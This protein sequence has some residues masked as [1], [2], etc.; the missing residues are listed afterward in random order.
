MTSSRLKLIGGLLLGL[1][2][3][4]SGI[5]CG[6]LGDSLYVGAVQNQT[7]TGITASY[8]FFNGTET[9]NIA[10]TAGDVIDFSYKSTVAE[11]SLALKLNDA[12]KNTVIEFPADTS[13]VAS[14]TAQKAGNFTLVIHGED[15][16]G[17]YDISWE[18]NKK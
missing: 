16:K 17:S 8:Q 6:S 18:I 3:I 15:T 12:D 9:K 10:V 2:I 5:S 13:G 4:V 1:A 7:S 11:G 14:I